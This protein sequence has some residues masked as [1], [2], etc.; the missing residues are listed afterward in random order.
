[1]EKQLEDLVEKLTAALGDR[2]VSVILYGSAAAGDWQERASD[3]NVLC[4]LRSITV[5]EMKLAESVFQWWS[6]Q[7][8]LP[9][10][11][12]TEDELTHSADCFPMEF[13]DILE[14]RRVLAG[15]DVASKIEID[16][17]YYRAFIERELRS[18]LIRLRRKSV[19]LLGQHDQLVKLM[20]DSISTFCALGR[21][22]LILGKRPTRWKKQEVLAAI[23]EATGS[24]MGAANRLL[25]IRESGKKPAAVDVLPLL[26]EYLRDI[27]VIVNFVDS[28]DKQ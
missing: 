26:D 21:H 15:R 14:R 10:V 17:T 6:K 12:M 2:I 20:L 11:L 1:M 9:P 24:Q 7:G 22:A 4:V 27:A 28:L 23:S 13:H 8:N 3:L 16:F 5:D 18:K 25:T 19:E